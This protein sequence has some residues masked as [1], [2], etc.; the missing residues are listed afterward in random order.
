MLD[1]V[2]PSLPGEKLLFRIVSTSASVLLTAV[3]EAAEDRTAARRP[4]HFEQD[5][6]VFCKVFISVMYCDV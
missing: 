1:A 3:A 6:Y 4:G 5:D 2:I